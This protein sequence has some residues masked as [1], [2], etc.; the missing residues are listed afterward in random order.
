M[1]FINNLISP[2]RAKKMKIENMTSSN[3]NKIANQFIYRDGESTVFQSYSSVIAIRYSDGRIE[4]DADKWDYSTTTGKYR[5]QFLGETKKETEAKIK[6]GE[7]KLKNL[8]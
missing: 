1:E 5:N 6:S 4:L 3:G 2:E 8:N 7:Y